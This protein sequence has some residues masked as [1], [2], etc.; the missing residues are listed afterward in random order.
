MEIQ[1]DRGEL[2][3]QTTDITQL[4]FSD[5]IT[6]YR[7]E[8]ASRKRGHRSEV[9]Y[10]N[11]LLRHPIAQTKLNCLTTDKLC[12]YRDERSKH[13]KPSS[14]KRRFAVLH[15]CFEVAI[16]EW[17]IALPRNPISSI[18]LPTGN[19]SRERRLR[20]NEGTLIEDA[21][22]TPS[23]A[24]LRP[25]I[26]MAIETGMRKGELLSIRWVDVDFDAR[27]VKILRTKNGHP[28]T[29]PL[30][31]TA[32]QTLSAMK[33]DAERVF[34]ISD[35]AVRFAW[36][37]MRKRAGIPDLRF[38]DLRHEGI[39]RLFEAGLNVPEVAMVSGHRSPA[40]LFRYTHPKPE[41]VAAK[42][43]TRDTQGLKGGSSAAGPEASAD[44]LL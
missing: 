33:R 13:L 27:T 4:T 6:R 24:Y 3:T 23:A 21:L 41:H 9:F 39:S 10:L 1:A 26:T 25:L 5:L 20:H 43:A 14:L 11:S 28:R 19:V 12:A 34:P 18:K 44:D 42:L 38:H 15:N 37:R 40:M 29:V 36:E 16:R 7:D 2:A 17:G 30:S 32:I 8:I 22:N 35:N 31:P